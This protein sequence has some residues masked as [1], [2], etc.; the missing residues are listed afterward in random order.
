MAVCNL[1]DGLVGFAEVVQYNLA[2][3]PE[4]LCKGIYERNKRF[5]VFVGDGTILLWTYNKILFIMFLYYL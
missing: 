3:L 5:D 4:G 2:I 1:N